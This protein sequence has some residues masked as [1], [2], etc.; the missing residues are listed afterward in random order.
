MEATP[1]EILVENLDHPSSSIRIWMMKL[2][3]FV[4]PW[5]NIVE[6]SGHLCRNLA[7]TLAWPLMAAGLA[8][9]CYDSWEDFLSF[10]QE[11]EDVEHKEQYKSRLERISDVGE[12]SV[13]APFWKLESECR[14]QIEL[15][16]FKGSPDRHAM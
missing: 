2:A 5:L 10:A 14:K 9:R 15:V 8:A 13:Q 12:L 11:Y 7:D 16:S 4:H 3:W 1:V 6:A